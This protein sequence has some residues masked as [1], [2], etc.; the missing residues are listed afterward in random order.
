MNIYI[1]IELYEHFY[2]LK[3]DSTFVFKVG[4]F[5][6][7]LFKGGKFKV[8]LFKVGKDNGFIKA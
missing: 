1:M 3:C 8:Y 5:K 4:K 6:V 7:Y 2:L